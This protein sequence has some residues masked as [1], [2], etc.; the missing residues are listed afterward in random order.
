MERILEGKGTEETLPLK[1]RR[2]SEKDSWR[3]EGEEKSRGDFVWVQGQTM[4]SFPAETNS[5]RGGQGEN[6]LTAGPW[7]ERPWGRKATAAVKDA[8]FR[9]EHEWWGPSGC[10]RDWEEGQSPARDPECGISDKAEMAHLKDCISLKWPI[11]YLLLQPKSLTCSSR[12]W[13]L[14]EAFL[15]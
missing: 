4:W 14:P 5:W 15:S 6:R 7:T 13:V 12:M 1:A 11:L 9:A 3:T 10:H 8:S 2:A